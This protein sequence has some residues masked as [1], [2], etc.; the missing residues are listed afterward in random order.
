MGPIKKLKEALRS[1]D[2]QLRNISESFSRQTSCL[3]QRILELEQQAKTQAEAQEQ[4]QKR[5]REEL[6]QL[7]PCVQALEKRADEA[8]EELTQLW[9]CARSLERRAEDEQRERQTQSEQ[10]AA[11]EGTFAEHQKD[12][13]ND[14]WMTKFGYDNLIAML[15]LAQTE[16]LV[17]GNRARLEALRNTH[18]GETCFVIG[19]GPSL[20]A[21]DLTAL[22]EK[23][24]FCFG[25]KRITAIFDE[26]PWRPDV[27][28]V[29]DFNFIELYHEEMDRLDG[30]LKLV[31]CQSILLKNI[32]IRDAVYFPF[33]HA[34]R[35]PSWFN[36]DVTRGVHFWGTITAKL[37][38]FAAYMGFTKIYLLGVDHSWPTVVGKDGKHRYDTVAAAHFSEKYYDTEADYKKAVADIENANE[39][40][41]YM[42]QGFK[43]IKYHCDQMGV[44]IF[45][46]TRG[47]E[48]EVFPRVNFDEMKNSL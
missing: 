35:T 38:N 2:E 27:W 42:T 15:Q 47:G 26:T 40:H 33:I 41:E 17:P 37:I 45:N 19:N 28:G 9:E 23:G 22:K 4:N 31:P 12:R 16:Q 20:R 24:V 11:F 48:L 46:A 36:A 14:H 30:F 13:L 7:W 25:S 39:M 5:A 1:I 18:A 21:D 29:S 44:E 6:A 3:E 34:E 43:A 8:R 10:L 32:F